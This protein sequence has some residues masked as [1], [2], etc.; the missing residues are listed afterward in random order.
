MLSLEEDN[1]NYELLQRIKERYNE[2]YDFI[3]ET[4]NPTWKSIMYKIRES[5]DKNKFT[6]Q[7][8]PMYLAL[9]DD[10]STELYAKLY[11]LDQ[12]TMQF[13]KNIVHMIENLGCVN[14]NEQWDEDVTFLPAGAHYITCPNCNAKRGYEKPEIK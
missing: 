5:I 12:E 2:V 1:K 3:Y 9:S 7:Y 6:E 11:E 4:R 14:C 13:Q 8:C 10:I